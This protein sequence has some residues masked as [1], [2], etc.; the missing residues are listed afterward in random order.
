M[1]IVVELLN[2]EV[3]KRLVGSS[4]F[5]KFEVRF[6]GVTQVQARASLDGFGVLHADHVYVEPSGLIALAGAQ[7]NE[8]MWMR[9]FEAMVVY[10]RSK[11]W[12]DE[13]GRLRAHIVRE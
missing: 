8:E 6:V 1:I 10:A 2:G 4:D 5:A 9:D 12:L 13:A 3:V 7:S 11:G